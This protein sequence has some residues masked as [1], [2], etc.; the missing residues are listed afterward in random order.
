MDGIE[1]KSKP[2]ILRPIL[3]GIIVLIGLGI[4]GGG[5]YVYQ[6]TMKGSKVVIEKEEPLTAEITPEVEEELTSTPTPTIVLDRKD[7][8]IKILNGTGVPGSASKGAKFLEALGYSKIDTGNADSFD[9][10]ETVIK[11]KEDKKEY[12]SLIKQD[13]AERYTLNEEEETLKEEE[14]YDVIIILG[15]EKI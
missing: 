9:Y 1:Q 13:L 11:I 4:V 6:K 3:I 14:N 8:K 7:L 12:L 10:K 15:E 2:D 5:I